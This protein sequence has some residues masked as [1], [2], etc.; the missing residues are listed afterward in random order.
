MKSIVAILKAISSE[1]VVSI[2][3]QELGE[4]I[5]GK[6]FYLVLSFFFL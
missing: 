6:D 3:S 1:Y 2:C 5:N 4:Y